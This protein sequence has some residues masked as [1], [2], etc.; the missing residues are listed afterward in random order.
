MNKVIIVD[1]ETGG[2]DA[3]KHSILSLGA[4]AVENYKIIDEF[5]VLIREP[6]LHLTPEAMRINKIDILKISH[7]G[8]SAWD[9]VT[10]FRRYTMDHFMPTSKANLGGHNIHF[11]VSFLKR[12]WSFGVTELYYDA[13][14][15]HRII[16]TASI[17]RF[18]MMSGRIE[19]TSA[20]LTDACKYFGVTIPEGERHTALGDARA[21][22]NLLIK[23]ME[24][25]RQ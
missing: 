17:I 13:C 1:T 7:E 24:L 25:I 4:V 10:R 12:L 20:G 6:V 2:L 15:S 18:L 21:T 16:D 11:D 8:V 14:F 23:M 19:L 22:A 5:E 9:A 3:S